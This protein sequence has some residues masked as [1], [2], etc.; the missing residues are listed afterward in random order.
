MQIIK[1]A[2]GFKEEVL[3]D[4]E[5]EHRGFAGYDI[6]LQYLDTANTRCQGKWGLVLLSAPEIAKIV[7]P[8]HNHPIAVIP[9][10]GL[11]VY[12]AAQR[13]QQLPKDQMPDCWERIIKIKDRDF[14]KM[15]LALQI[16]NSVLTH[17]DGVHRLL[18][19]GLFKMDQNTQEVLAYVAGLA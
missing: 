12:D 5:V 8:A 3:R 1:A 13:L 11:S 16:E 18:S 7:L 10:S 15:H 19:Y 17:V 4:Y 9:E 6:G 14:S 2:V